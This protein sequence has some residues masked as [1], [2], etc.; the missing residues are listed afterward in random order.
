[1]KFPLFNMSPY[2]WVDESII[3]L[4]LFSKFIY[5]NDDNYFNTCLRNNKFCDCNG[6]IYI[7]KGKTSPTQP[8]RK[9][10]RFIPGI[11]KVTLLF[12]KTNESITFNEFKV[13]FITKHS[14]IQNKDILTKHWF[15]LVKSSESFGDLYNH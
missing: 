14:A 12:E 1:M 6:I 15:N 2:R 9:F 4:A 13:F 10:L 5:T 3:D 11:F 8:W 7:I